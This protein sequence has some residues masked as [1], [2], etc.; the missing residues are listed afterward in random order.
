MPD[1]ATDRGTN[2]NIDDTNL[3]SRPQVFRSFPTVY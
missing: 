2:K 1:G 3:K